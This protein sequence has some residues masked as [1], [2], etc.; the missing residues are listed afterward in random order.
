MLVGNTLTFEA[1]VELWW[2]ELEGIQGIDVFYL[3]KS[4]S[5]TIETAIV[6][7][8]DLQF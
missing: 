2:L 6:W 7:Q 1:I 8:L 4:S 5:D 3:I